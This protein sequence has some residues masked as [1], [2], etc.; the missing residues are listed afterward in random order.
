MK[1]NCI[2]SSIVATTLKLVTVR[3]AYFLII[4]FEGKFITYS[5]FNSEKLLL[6]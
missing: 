5:T 2:V 4:V 3:K 1:K 6:N